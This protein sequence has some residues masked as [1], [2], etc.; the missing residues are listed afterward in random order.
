MLQVE[1]ERE[2]Y[3]TCL[4]VG[5]SVQLYEFDDIRTAFLHFRLCV[6]EYFQQI[7]W[8]L[9]RFSFLFYECLTTSQ[10]NS[11][12]KLILSRNVWNHCMSYSGKG[13][14]SIK[15]NV[16]MSWV[17]F[18]MRHFMLGSYEGNEKLNG[19]AWATKKWTLIVHNHLMAPGIM[20]M[21]YFHINIINSK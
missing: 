11:V 7:Y 15:L 20:R 18:F 13:G 4:L 8:Y 2:R 16:A 12:S 5:K 14:I 3:R 19:E 1:R 21:T 10:G 17:C 9:S 6:S